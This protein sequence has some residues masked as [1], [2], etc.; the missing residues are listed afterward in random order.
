MEYFSYKGVCNVHG[1]RTHMEA[2]KRRCGLGL[3]VNG[4][5][6]LVIYQ[7]GSGAVYCIV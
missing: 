1:R 4:L 2:F 3:Q 5:G 6:L 7:S